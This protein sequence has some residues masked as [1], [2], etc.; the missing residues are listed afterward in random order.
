MLYCKPYTLFTREGVKV[1]HF[2]LSR[3]RPQR[4]AHPHV[5]V[6]MVVIALL[7]VGMLLVP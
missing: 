3:S 2:A 7:V 6:V 4:G 1:K 5:G